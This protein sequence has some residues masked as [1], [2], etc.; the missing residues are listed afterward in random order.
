[1]MCIIHVRARH[2]AARVCLE[3]AN[4]RARAIGKECGGN[5][6]AALNMVEFDD[7]ELKHEFFE[8]ADK[9]TVSQT[10]TQSLKITSR[11]SEVPPCPYIELTANII[12]DVS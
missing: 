2:Q 4:G 10:R 9:K 3:Q 12:A 8:T 11:Y 7:E 6:E 5:V 1:M